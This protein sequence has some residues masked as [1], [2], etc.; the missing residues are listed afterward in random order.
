MSDLKYKVGDVVELKKPINNIHFAEIVEIHEQDGIFPYRVC[1]E[2]ADCDDVIYTWIDDN[3]IE[4]LIHSAD[5][6]NK[7]LAEVEKK[8]GEIIN[9]HIKAITKE[10]IEI[11]KEYEEH[12]NKE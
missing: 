2:N 6:S 10:L 7:E 1:Q 5:E 8:L 9:K 4:C 3:D 11:I 12:G